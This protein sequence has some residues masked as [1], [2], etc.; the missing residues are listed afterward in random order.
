MRS[1]VKRPA[2]VGRRARDNHL[3]LPARERRSGRSLRLQDGR[4]A[5]AP[6]PGSRPA[7]SREP[8][9]AP[10][11]IESAER[12]LILDA[13]DRSSR[14]VSAAAR[15]LGI[16]R[17]TLRYRMRKYGL[18]PELDDGGSEARE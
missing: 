4:S 14:N 16:T 15:L 6:T 9:P 18:D 10:N 12:S 3:M 5:P 11:Q 1:A 8:G 2:G 17:N 7:A 13:L